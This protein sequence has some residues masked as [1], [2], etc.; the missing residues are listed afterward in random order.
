MPDIAREDSSAVAA[1][2]RQAVN[3]VIQGTASDLIK[4]AMVLSFQQLATAEEVR[5]VMQ[6]HDELI[7]EVPN[8]PL[9]LSS[10]TENLRRIMEKEVVEFMH[11]QVPLIAN[12]SVGEKWGEMHPWVST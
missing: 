11:L 3:T 8:N 6:I 9:F 1:A 5:L 4:L 10:F 2:E 7:F 12:I